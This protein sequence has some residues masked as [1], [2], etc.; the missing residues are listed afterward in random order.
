MENALAMTTIRALGKPEETGDATSQAAFAEIVHSN[1]RLVHRIALAVTRNPD[2]AEDVVQECFLQFY[3]NAK[4]P[5]IDDHRAYLART[6]WR[7]AL[8]RAARQSGQ[9]LPDVLIS[10][11]AGPE[12]EAIARQAETAIHI[13]ID[14]LPEKLRQPLVLSA[15]DELTSPEIA[16]ILGIPEGTVRRRIHSARELL[17]SQWQQNP[18]RSFSK[19]GRA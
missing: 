11:L 2:D 6:A 9:Q 3:R 16:A 14:R 15:I 13:L 1:A 10:P 7:T 8:R 5:Q 4:W 19:G 17:R 12:R 18:T